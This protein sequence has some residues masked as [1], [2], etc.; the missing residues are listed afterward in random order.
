[1]VEIGNM[2]YDL[3]EE[4]LDPNSPAVIASGSQITPREAILSFENA[5]SQQ[6]G[7][8][9]GDSDL[10]PLTHSF[11]D[12]IYVREI[13]IPKGVVLTGKIHKHD[14][15]NFLMKGKV[16]VFTEHDGFEVLTAPCHMI[17]KAG[18][19]RAVEAMEDTV[20]VTV[21]HNPTNT[22]DLK[23]IE[24]NVIAP[25]YSHFVKFVASKTGIANKLKSFIIK[26]ICK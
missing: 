7:A 14:H 8:V 18:T 5:L 13:F 23:K 21:H 4:K 6:E 11:S 3:V 26:L 22:E 19:K 15:P 17:S 24:D 10:C 12:G 9:F 25:S 20:W 2:K 16:K 1:M